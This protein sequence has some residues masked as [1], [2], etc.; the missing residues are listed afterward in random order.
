TLCQWQKR[1]DPNYDTYGSGT[2]TYSYPAR[3]A[4]SDVGA[5]V[6]AI[7]TTGDI[8]KPLITVAGTLD[9]LLPINL[10][11]RAYARAV[12]A[13]SAQGDE[14]GKYRQH[15]SSAY[16]LY[17]VQNGNHIETYLDGPPPA[18]AFPELELIQPHAHRAFELLT[19]H[20]ER[21]ADLPP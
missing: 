21:G 12:A 15:I 18:P 14:D 9:A 11:A 20:V 7:A 2:G 1:L 3:L 13:A 19:D 5:N 10:Q 17:E 8:G 4:A 6:A 16:R